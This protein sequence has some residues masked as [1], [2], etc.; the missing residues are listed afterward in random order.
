[1]RLVFK[2]VE[3]RAQQ[4]TREEHSRTEK[5]DRIFGEASHQKMEERLNAHAEKLNITREHLEAL[6]AKPEEYYAFLESR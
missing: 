2:D 5:H 1:M 4:L 3:R 6:L